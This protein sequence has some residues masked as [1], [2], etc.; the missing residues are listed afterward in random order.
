MSCRQTAHFVSV[1]PGPA[2]S[3]FMAKQGLQPAPDLLQAHAG[4]LTRITVPAH[5]IQQ[6]QQQ[7]A[8]NSTSPAAG[9]QFKHVLAV[10]ASMRSDATAGA[11][12]SS[13]AAHKAKAAACMS[14]ASE[15]VETYEKRKAAAAASVKAASLSAQMAV[16]A[17]AKQKAKAV[18]L[19][20]S[21]ARETSNRV[22][23]AF[24]V[25]QRLAASHAFAQSV[26]TEFALAEYESHPACQQS[27][28][29]GALSYF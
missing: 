28:L 6:Q 10:Q 16:R 21:K 19:G 14:A 20:P 2:V 25:D 27:W 7:A 8:A 13:G 22:A 3:A 9:F 1:K 15:A 11:G 4:E 17:L 12:S 29:A 24:P 5:L 26:D 23:G 18:A